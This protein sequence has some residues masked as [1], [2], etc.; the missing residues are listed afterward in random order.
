MGIG[1]KTDSPFSKTRRFAMSSRRAFTLIEFLVL[2]AIIALIIAILIPAVGR[3]C[4]CS[5]MAILRELETRVSIKVNQ[6][7]ADPFAVASQAFYESST[8]HKLNESGTIYVNPVA[9]AWKWENQDKDIGLL[10]YKNKSNGFIVLF[11]DGMYTN[12]SSKEEAFTKA[13]WNTIESIPQLPN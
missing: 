3:G 5:T 6:E 2:I 12:L 9:A 10:V 1:R 11:P 13:H 7:S 8:F 4:G